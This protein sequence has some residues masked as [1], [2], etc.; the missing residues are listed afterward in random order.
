M[1]TKR[2]P[3]L[4][5]RGNTWHINKKVDGV[6]I[7]ESTGTGELKEAERYLARRLETHR[8]AKVYGVRPKR[9]FR[10]AA[11]KFLLEN[12]HKKS[13]SDDACSLKNAGSLYW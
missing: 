12:Q 9:S 10:E 3:G 6:R 11:T 5:K 4:V 2:T 13:L 1:G 8:Q 7:C